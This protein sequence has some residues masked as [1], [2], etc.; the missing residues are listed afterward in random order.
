MT[1]IERT[2]SSQDNALWLLSMSEE[3]VEDNLTHWFAI[4]EVLSVNGYEIP[5]QWEFRPGAIRVEDGKEN[6]IEQWPDCEWATLLDSD[7]V[8]VEDLIAIGW[9]LAEKLTEGEPK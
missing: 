3:T 4:C 8:T 6:I 9:E 5:E 1:T 2:F 7:Q